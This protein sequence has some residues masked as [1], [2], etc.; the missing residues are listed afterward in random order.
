[1]STRIQSVT[2]AASAAGCVMFPNGCDFNTTDAFVGGGFLERIV[3]GNAGSGTTNIQL[4]VYEARNASTGRVQIGGTTTQDAFRVIGGTTAVASPDG[5]VHFV[6][7]PNAVDI[8]NGTTGCRKLIDKLNLGIP[9]GNR[10]FSLDLGL[11]IPSGIIVVVGATGANSALQIGVA[12]TPWVS[13]WTRR[14]R[15]Y[16]ESG[17]TKLNTQFAPQP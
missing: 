1:M 3:F 4:D 5:S 6:N 2:L 8:T 9:T 17:T 15:A 16:G 12:F 11:S 14:R 7:A 10:S 13:G